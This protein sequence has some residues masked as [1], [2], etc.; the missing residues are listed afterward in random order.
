MSHLII[1]A[2]FVLAAVKAEEKA[3][4]N[5]TNQASKERLEARIRDAYLRSGMNE[6][7]TL[8]NPRNIN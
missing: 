6:N 8:I 1:T 7:H 5:L 2:I 4:E 3:R